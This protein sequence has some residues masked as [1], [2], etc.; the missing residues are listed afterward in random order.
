MQG[1][2]KLYHGKTKATVERFQYLKSNSEAFIKYQ[3]FTCRWNTHIFRNIN[4]KAENEKSDKFTT[5]IVRGHTDLLH[6]GSGS[7]T[8][9]HSSLTKR[10]VCLESEE[11]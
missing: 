10:S 11:M 2:Q 4:K 5:D 1:F 9:S 6:P 8:L 3:S 7:T